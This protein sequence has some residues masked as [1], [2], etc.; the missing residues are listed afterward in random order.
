MGE[1]PHEEREEEKEEEEEEK[2]EWFRV[3]L[4]VGWL[5]LGNGRE[6]EA[7]EG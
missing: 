5:G 4:L 6:E 7:R 2:K 1:S 3:S